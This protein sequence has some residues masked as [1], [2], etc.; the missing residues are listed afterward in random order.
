MKE[1]DTFFGNGWCGATWQWSIS[2]TALCAKDP[3]HDGDHTA[4]M[5]GNGDCVAIISWEQM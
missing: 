3:G 2:F 4:S 1:D 5:A